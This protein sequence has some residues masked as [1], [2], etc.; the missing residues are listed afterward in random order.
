[1]A[2]KKDTVNKR[3]ISTQLAKKYN[4]PQTTVHKVI[5]GTLEAIIDILAK[6]GRLELRNFGVFLVKTRKPRP[7]RNPK[8]GEPVMIPKRKVV[9]F[10][11]GAVMHK[12]VK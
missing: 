5:Q 12:K 4:I 9:V 3:L 7:A 8:T 11:A 6:E 10:K 2:V 1:M